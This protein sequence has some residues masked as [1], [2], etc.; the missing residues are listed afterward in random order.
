MVEHS[1]FSMTMKQQPNIESQ[2]VLA[3][4]KF[5]ASEK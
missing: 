4:E 3:R 5:V 1:A 2:Q